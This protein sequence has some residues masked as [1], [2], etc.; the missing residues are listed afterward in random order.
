MKKTYPVPHGENDSD[1][2]IQLNEFLNNYGIATGNHASLE[3]DDEGQPIIAYESAPE[4]IKNTNKTKI[5]HPEDY[6]YFDMLLRGETKMNGELQSGNEKSL[7]M[8]SDKLESTSLRKE[9][10]SFNDQTI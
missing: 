7:N 2:L 10:K 4:P 3:F 8:K 1:F 6:L 9:R 5:K